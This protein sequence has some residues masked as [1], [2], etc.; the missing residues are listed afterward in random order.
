MDENNF[1]VVSGCYKLPSVVDLCSRVDQE[2]EEHEDRFTVSSQTKLTDILVNRQSTLRYRQQA[3]LY[4]FTNR[5]KEAV[6]LVIL[7]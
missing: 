7:L 4:S 2:L 5:L 6:R 3:Y 1:S